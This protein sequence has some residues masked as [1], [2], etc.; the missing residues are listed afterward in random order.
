MYI[1]INNLIQK[2]GVAD[3]KGLDLNNIVCGT[4]LYPSDNKAYFVYDMELNAEI[5]SM[6]D[7]EVIS[8]SQYLEVKNEIE[9]ESPI[10]L[11]EEIKQLKEQNTILE[12]AILDLANIA[13]GV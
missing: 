4:Q 10:S 1:K 12:N 13:G 5:I 7:V 9:K 11:E 8:E 2:N 6:V 3:Y